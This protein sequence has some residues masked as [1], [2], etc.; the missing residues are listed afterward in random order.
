M[1]TR[2]NAHEAYRAARERLDERLNLLNRL[3]RS[4]DARE[5][6]DRKDWGYVGDLN[7]VIEKMDEVIESLGGEKENAK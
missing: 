7:H 3:I 2:T 4:H 1:E 6:R 5:F